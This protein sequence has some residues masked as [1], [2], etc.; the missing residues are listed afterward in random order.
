[1]IR[2]LVIVLL[3]LLTV[4]SVRADRTLQVGCGDWVRL[5]ATP[6]EGYAFL[7]WSDGDARPEREVQ[8]NG[9]EHYIA[10]FTPLCGDYAAW[11]VVELYDWVIMLNLTQINAMGFYPSPLS[12]RWYRVV[13]QM[14]EVGADVRDDELM[15]T[16]YY[17]TIEQ[18]FQG[19]G[20]YYAE[21]DISDSRA[22]LCSG[23]MRSVVVRYKVPAPAQAPESQYEKVLLDQRVYIRRD[24]VLYDVVGRRAQ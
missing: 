4:S 3:V 7:E 10:Y 15:A 20:D 5:T 12:T 16:G 24:D 9:D 21:C 14:D 22:T 1:M 18:N 17:L 6:L 11:P 23:I 8:V 13:G 19:T 2:R